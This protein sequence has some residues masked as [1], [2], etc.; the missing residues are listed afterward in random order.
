MSR[1]LNISK[2]I[3]WSLL[4]QIIVLGFGFILPKLIIETY[5]SNING[6][7]ATINQLLNLLNLLQAGAVGATIFAMFK[8]VAEKNFYLISLIV[9]TSKKYFFKLGAIFLL[10]VVVVASLSAINNTNY[11]IKSWEIFSSFIIL[12]INTS[13]SFFFIYKYDILFSS[14]QKRYVLSISSNIERLIYFSL[15]FIILNLN[16]HFIYMYISVIIGGICRIIFLEKSFKKQMAHHLLPIKKNKT[17]RIENKGYHLINQ[18]CTI[19]VESSPPLL[20]SIIFNFKLVSVFSVYYLFVIATKSIMNL[21]QMSISEVFGNVMVM[22]NEIKIEK[23]FNFIVFIFFIVGT[24]IISTLA[25]NLM[26]FISLYTNGFND[27]DYIFPFLGLFI[28]INAM[29]YCI[30][31]PFYTLSNNFGLYKKF[32]KQSIISAATAV[33]ISFVFLEFVS[34]PGVLLGVLIYYLSSLIFRS[35]VLFKEITW[36]R[37]RHFYKRLFFYFSIPLIV[38]FIQQSFFYSAT[39]WSVLII[40]CIITAIA[41]FIIII[42]YTIIFEREMILE[43]KTYITNLKKTKN[44]EI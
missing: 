37:I 20:I 25:F 33:L 17:Y 6:L 22:E 4:G 2:N 40:S 14:H 42:F 15:L 34:F 13:F 23:V 32:H 12:G 26:P 3:L 41:S 11:E 1:T 43:I 19:A 39:N 38:F 18:I 8:P 9:F 5:G 44:N 16:I 31:M 30:Y 10:L 7:T 21:I 36:F 27:A 35:Y 28:L 29:L 24:F